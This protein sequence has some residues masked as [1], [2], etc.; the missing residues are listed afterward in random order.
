MKVNAMQGSYQILYG[1]TNI[2]AL[3][4]TLCGIYWMKLGCI[5][6]KPKD[7]YCT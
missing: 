7:A 5:D 3:N 4:L 1:K 2:E 6:Q